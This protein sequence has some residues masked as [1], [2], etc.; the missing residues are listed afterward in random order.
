MEAIAIIFYEKESV[1][2]DV[3][4]NQDGEDTLLFVVYH[5]HRITNK[6]VLLLP[7]IL[8]KLLK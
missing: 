8:L 1:H 3:I 7:Y 4:N 6:N 2:E 5:R